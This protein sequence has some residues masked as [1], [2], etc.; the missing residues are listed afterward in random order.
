MS[1]ATRIRRLGAATA[2]AIA[3]AAGGTAIILN[4]P[5]LAGSDRGPALD[6]VR[7]KINDVNVV[8]PSRAVQESALISAGSA[9]PLDI[10]VIGGGATGSGAALDAVTRGL[11]VGLVERE[12]F[13]SGTSSRSTKLIHGGTRFDSIDALI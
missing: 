6:V 10:L 9:N 1:S 11:R 12:D 7:R 13:S 3:A 5:S 4:N 8:V 2:A